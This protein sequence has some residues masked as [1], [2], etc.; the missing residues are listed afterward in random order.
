MGRNTKKIPLPKNLL[1]LVKEE[2]VKSNLKKNPGSILLP[3]FIRIMIDA[4]LFS[5][6][7]KDTLPRTFV[8]N[9]FGVVTTSLVLQVPDKKINENLYFQLCRINGL[10]KCSS[11]FYGCSCGASSPL[12]E[13]YNPSFPD[14]TSAVVHYWERFLEYAERSPVKEKTVSTMKKYMSFWV[15]LSEEEKLKTLSNETKV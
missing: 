11:T 7:V 6:L 10:W 1:F 9:E 4:Y 2:L 12:T 3:G 14:L 5:F 8:V 13:K 15:S